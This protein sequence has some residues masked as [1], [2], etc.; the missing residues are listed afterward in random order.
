MNIQALTMAELTAWVQ[1]HLHKAGIPTV[2]SVRRQKTKEK[3][4]AK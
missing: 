2:L 1:T 4:R 3:H